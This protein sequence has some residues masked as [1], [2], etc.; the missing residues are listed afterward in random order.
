M[1]EG[2]EAK[3]HPELFLFLGSVG[4]GCAGVTL[5]GPVGGPLG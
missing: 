4:G 1:D 3:P 2:S 5:G